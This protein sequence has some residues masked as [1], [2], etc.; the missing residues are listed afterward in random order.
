MVLL[1]RQVESKDPSSSMDREV[2][3][4]LL[5]DG[6]GRAWR[7]EDLYDKQHSLTGMTSSVYMISRASPHTLSD[8]SHVQVHVCVWAFLHSYFPI[9]VEKLHS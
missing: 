1:L 4:S 6:V 7:A 2:E 5:I 3:F 8:A 9:R